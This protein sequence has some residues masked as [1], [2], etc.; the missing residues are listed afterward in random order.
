[1][2]E[3]EK[4]INNAPLRPIP[5]EW[6][7]DI[8]RVAKKARLERALPDYF[9]FAIF[10]RKLLW[11]HPVAWA[12]L[13]ACW[14]LAAV[15][16]FSGPRGPELYAVTPQGVTPYP[17]TTGSYAAYVALRNQALQDT[18]PAEPAVR[19]FERRKL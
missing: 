5:P 15:L 17:F 16:C 12:V 3:L 6:R 11:P 1:M 8:L 7:E 4:Q 13:A 19:V 14:M 18:S 2:T 10:L 9:A